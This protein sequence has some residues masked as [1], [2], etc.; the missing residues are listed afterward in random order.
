MVYFKATPFTEAGLDI[1]RRKNEDLPADQLADMVLRI[2]AE[3]PYIRD[4][5]QHAALRPT[6]KTS[7]S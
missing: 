6:E 4:L 7:V 2:G 5:L 3:H 1:L